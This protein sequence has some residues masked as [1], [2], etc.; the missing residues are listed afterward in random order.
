[1]VL[2]HSKWSLYTLICYEDVNNCKIYAY[3]II[4]NTQE[5]FLPM[6]EI[7]KFIKKS[8]LQIII[9]LL[10]FSSISFPSSDCCDIEPHNE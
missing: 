4:V 6:Q 3:I 8:Q 10:F 2:M 1:M 7:R 5:H 9:K